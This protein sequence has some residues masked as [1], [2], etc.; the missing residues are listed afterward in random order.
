M[1]TAAQSS[2]SAP[3]PMRARPTTHI[4]AYDRFRIDRSRCPVEPEWVDGEEVYTVYRPA[5]ERA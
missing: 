5:E 4:D 1:P 2:R 3:R